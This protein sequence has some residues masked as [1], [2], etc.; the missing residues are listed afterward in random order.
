MRAGIPI[1]DCL[2]PVHHYGYAEKERAGDHYLRAG[3]RKVRENPNDIRA[4]YEL[5]IAYR[6]ADRQDEALGE[7]ESALSGASN[8]DS[9]A[10]IYVQEELMLLVRADIL[11]RMGRKAEALAA[12]EAL[13]ERFPDSHQALNNKG[14]LLEDQGLIGEARR[15]YERALSL[16]GDNE[17]LAENVARV[18]A[19]HTLSVCVL[20][21]GDGAPLERCLESVCDVADQVIVVD[22]GGNGQTAA[23]V[24]RFGVTRM[25]VEWTG[26]F[27]AVRNAALDE[28]K[29][30]IGSCVWMQKSICVGK[31]GK[32]SFRSKRLKPNRGL[33]VS[34]IGEEGSRTQA[35]KIAFPNRPTI[36]FE[37]PAYEN[38]LNAI[39]SA[40]LRFNS[41]ILRCAEDRMPM[42][43]MRAASRP[44]TMI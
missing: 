7:I 5:A 4:R 11:T 40:E 9:A 32:K 8:A 23:S 25:S 43:K 6:N 16:V 3:E 41:P 31:T 33:C 24:E 18:S 1:G 20:V 37:Q 14:I 39:R 36:R 19:E 22:L 13:L 28:S 42:R 29:L 15:C 17:T 35:V 44:T 38:V 30:A 34:V 2:V 12:Y 21:R 10:L 26:D 27:P